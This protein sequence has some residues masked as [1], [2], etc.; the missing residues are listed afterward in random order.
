MKGN[1]Q[2]SEW[3]IYKG[4][5]VSLEAGASRNIK[6]TRQCNDP[7]QGILEVLYWLRWVNSVPLISRRMEVLWSFH[8]E[9]IICGC[10]E[11]LSSQLRF[12]HT[13]SGG[14]GDLPVNSWVHCCWRSLL[15]VLRR[16]T[17]VGLICSL[18]K[19]W[20]LY[21]MWRIQSFFHIM[22]SYSL[23]WGKE[24]IFQVQIT[25]LLKNIA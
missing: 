18:G 3:V 23:Y 10:Q 13:S 21:A 22:E 1:C 6:T 15:E 12:S 17:L 11:M 8:S 2:L 20:K 9:I 5:K 7:C 14:G 24:Q 16:I 25:F 19:D 4:V